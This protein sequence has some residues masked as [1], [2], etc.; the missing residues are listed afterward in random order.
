MRISRSGMEGVWLSDGG[1][2]FLAQCDLASNRA[3]PS[4]AEPGAVLFTC[5]PAAAKGPAS[6]AEVDMKGPSEAELNSP[7]EAELEGPLRPP[8][9]RVGLRRGAEGQLKGVTKQARAAAGQAAAAKLMKGPSRLLATA[10]GPAS[11]AANATAGPGP[12]FS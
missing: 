12:E 7:S 10:K 8:S 4:R 5:I 6:A 9:K 1:G 11:A 3:G 2:A